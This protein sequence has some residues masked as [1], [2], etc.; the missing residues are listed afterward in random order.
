MSET[1]GWNRPDQP[2]NPGS[3]FPPPPSSPQPGVIPLRP[4]GVGEI[5]D[6]AFATMRRHSGLVF[7]V[8]VV[9]AVTGALLDF[10]LTS[11]VVGEV[12]PL[13]PLGPAATEQE[14]LAWYTEVLRQSAA[15]S[16]ILVAI[17]VLTSTFLSGFMTTV[18]GKAVLGRP[19]V[20]GEVLA[21]LKPR[22]LP[23]LGLTVLYTFIVSIATVFFLVPGVWLYVLFGLAAPA[24]VLERSGIGSAFRRSRLLV[25]GNWWRVFGVLL[26]TLIVT[27][28]V[29]GIV[30][31]PFGL[32]LGLNSDVARYLGQ[33]VSSTVVT[34]FAAGASALLYID[35]RMRREGMDSQLARAAAA[36]Q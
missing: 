20:L 9:V 34:P 25:Q 10:A 27:V 24:L 1:G 8:S 33:V 13:R 19:A 32:S 17:G 12:A 7:G 4:L 5:L 11:G 29:K 18:V 6:G 28:L 22:L 30:E 35:Q 31:L 14:Q 26:L 21:E 16:A 15:Q 3:A 36:G 23:L 2:G